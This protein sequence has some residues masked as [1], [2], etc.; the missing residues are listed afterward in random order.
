LDKAGRGGPGRWPSAAAA[1]QSMRD[2][3][4][5]LLEERRAEAMAR[6]EAEAEARAA[7]AAAAAAV[8]T[9]GTT[10][11]TVLQ[12]VDEPRPL[13]SPD[14]LRLGGHKG[15]AGMVFGS[16]TSRPCFGGAEDW[17]GDH[18]DDDSDATS[19]V[20]TGH[21]TGGSA[22]DAG[23]RAAA[24]AGWKAADAGWTQGGKEPTQRG[25]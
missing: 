5:A 6:A 16:D 10:A 20:R 19:S 3:V 11:A 7:A 8:A 22:A 12:F 17:E 9:A 25:V 4:G 14:P 23:G 15:I 2:Y 13:T 21:C 24:D 1:A 18:V